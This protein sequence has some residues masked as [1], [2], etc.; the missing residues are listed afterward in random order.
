MRC[1]K[2]AVYLSLILVGDFQVRIFCDSVITIASALWSSLQLLDNKLFLVN[3]EKCHE[4]FCCR[5]G[6]L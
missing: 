3:S 6:V 5:L 4:E 1:M 2:A